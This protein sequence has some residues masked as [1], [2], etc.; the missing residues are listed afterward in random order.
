[1]ATKEWRFTQL[2]SQQ[3]TLVLAGRSAPFGRPRQK[4]VVSDGIRLRA[5]R[6]YYPDKAGP[7]TTHIFGIA[8]P[9]WELNGRFADKFLGAGETK[10]LIGEWQAFLADGQ[11]LLITWG[12][13]LTARGI[14]EE[15][16]P[17]RE[18]EFE[19]S[20][21]IK[22]FIDEELGVLPPAPGAFTVPGAS[23]LCAALQKELAS[24]A[25]SIPNAPN[26]GDLKPSFLDSL[27]DLVSSINTFSA[28]LVRIAG[29]FDT[30]ASGTMDQLERLRSG[31]VQI[32]TAV[33]RVRGTIDTT[34][35]DA[36]LLSRSA[37]MDVLWF[38]ARADIEVSTLR[39]LAL[40]DE[41][42]RQAEIA[43][44]GRAMTIYVAR[45]GDSWESIARQFYGGADKAGQ[46]RD[47]NGVRYGEIPTPGR[48]YQIPVAA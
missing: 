41:I 40:L 35:N 18:S 23:E 15:F 10:R 36:A 44:R 5:Q 32:R 25:A 13:I 3:K 2:G 37:D 8:Y 26:A 42:D 9:D 12:D 11:E 29:E 27:D 31:V 1:M 34:T 22:L 16:V 6:V 33:N 45:G 47:A 24:G 46:I 4:P 20:Y 48:S 38:S 28:S 17:G 19:S 14:L 7:P 21:A 30:F 43:Q 39:S